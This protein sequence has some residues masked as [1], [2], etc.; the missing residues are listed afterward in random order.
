MFNPLLA[1][2]LCRFNGSQRFP[3]LSSWQLELAL[4]TYSLEVSYGLQVSCGLQVSYGLQASCGLEAIRTVGV[5]FGTLRRKMIGLGVISRT[6][7]GVVG[8]VG[9]S[10]GNAASAAAADLGVARDY[11]LFLF[12]DLQHRY[13]DTEGTMAI[14]GNATLFNYAAAGTVTTTGAL[15]QVGNNVTFQHGIVGA[16][17]QGAIIYGNAANLS[18]LAYNAGASQQQPNLQTTLFQPAYNY[19][20]QLSQTLSNQTAPGQ[21][22]WLSNGQPSGLLS[23]LGNSSTVNI[24]NVGAG[25]LGNSHTLKIAAPQNSTVIVNFADTAVNWSGMGIQLT[26]LSGNDITNSQ[27]QHV[28]YNFN[29]AQNLSLSAI[30]INGSILAPH[31][32]IDFTNG[33][34]NGQVI[35][36][37]LRGGLV[38]AAGQPVGAPGGQINWQPFVGD[39][40]DDSNTTT[41]IPTPALL[42]GLLTMAMRAWKK[43]RSVT[44]V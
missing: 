23:L 33:V 20:S 43:R 40:P 36:D 27:R 15:L 35:A 11:N 17:G 32:A 12:G 25:L 16:N 18:N 3:S 24:F 22:S 31:A 28:L 19:L 21:V 41:D 42:P 5:R 6:A 7:I 34:V 1:T 44:S 37:S 2:T 13:T 29:N 14:G 10:M 30:G 26:D 9:L 39:L 38:D 8:L 4:V